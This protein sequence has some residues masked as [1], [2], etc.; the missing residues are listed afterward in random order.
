MNF[1]DNME[2][3]DV[4]G[5]PHCLTQYQV[6]IIL[7]IGWVSFLLSWLSNIIYYKFH[8]SGVD[9]GRSRSRLFIY[10]LGKKVE[11]LGYKEEM[12][13]EEFEDIKE[14]DK[15]NTDEK[16]VEDIEV[17]DKKKT[18]KMGIGVEKEA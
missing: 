9:V 3:R 7:I 5:R 4:N 12:E 8:P 15:L 2:I 1:S 11:L 13:V 10:F 17:D 18:G 6:Q 14:E 16:E